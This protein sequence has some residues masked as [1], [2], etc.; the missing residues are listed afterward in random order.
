[1]V[2][3]FNHGSI[4]RKENKNAE[5]KTGPACQV[6]PPGVKHHT[7][8]SCLWKRIRL[9]IN[10]QRYTAGYSDKEWI[11]FHLPW[12]GAYDPAAIPP[13]PESGKVMIFPDPGAN[14]YQPGQTLPLHVRL[15]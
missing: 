1:M 13:A 11:Q 14:Y 6:L 8:F 4:R 2:V 10:T 9:P 3:F 7:V 12:E 5:K 15:L